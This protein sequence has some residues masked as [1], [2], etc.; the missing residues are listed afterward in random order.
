MPMKKQPL[1]IRT[2]PEVPVAPVRIL[3]VDPGTRYMG[4]AI[5]IGGELLRS[6]V[7]NIRQVGMTSAKVSANA[8]RVLR[9]WMRRH[10]PDFL[11]VEPPH[12]AQSKGSRSL[13]RLVSA[14]RTLAEQEGVEMRCYLPT[15]VRRLVCRTGRPTRLAVAR[16]VADR[17]PWLGP[18]YRKEAAKS[19]S[20]KPYWL[21]M[22]D[23]IA[24]GLVCREDQ[25]RRRR[26]T[27]A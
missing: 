23:A 22:F 9:R 2:L 4:V 3:A 14:I 17:F 11:A 27:A 7:E 5:L 6:D 12:F 18:Y 25:T 19:W 10:R 13:R 8:Q 21:S 26:R 1:T 24:V 15:T 16:E 20:R